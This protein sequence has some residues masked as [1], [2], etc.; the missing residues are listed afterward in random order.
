MYYS[1]E[2]LVTSLILCT[3]RQGKKNV[4]SVQK[5]MPA[6]TS[7]RNCR[8]KIIRLDNVISGSIDYVPYGQ[9]ANSILLNDHGVLLN[10]CQ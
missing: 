9:L 5:H 7:H 2:I 3:V 6:A 4:V 1:Q 8:G 10:P